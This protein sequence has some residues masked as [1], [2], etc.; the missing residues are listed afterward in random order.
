VTRLRAERLGFV[1][2][3]WVLGTLSTRVKRLGR[4]DDHLPLS[5]AEV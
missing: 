2:F 4:E 1:R 5:I 3:Q